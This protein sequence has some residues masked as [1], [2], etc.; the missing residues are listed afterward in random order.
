MIQVSANDSRNEAEMKGQANFD[1]NRLFFLPIRDDDERLRSDSFT[2]ASRHGGS[3]DAHP[4]HGGAA[5]NARVSHP[6][7]DGGWGNRRRRQPI[8]G[9]H[10]QAG[11]TRR[12][13][14]T[15]K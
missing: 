6:F 14:A 7:R 15:A 10:C 12:A 1:L 3:N 9:A 8:A 11:E 13:V 4:R 5:A 2:N